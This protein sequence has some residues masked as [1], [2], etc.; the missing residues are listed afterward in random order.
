MKCHKPETDLKRADN[1]RPLHQEM[2][3]IASLLFCLEARDGTP[4]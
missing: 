3:L 4:A 1:T 2:R